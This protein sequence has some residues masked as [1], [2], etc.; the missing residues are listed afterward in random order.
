MIREWHNS[1]ALLAL[2]LEAASGG[3]LNDAGD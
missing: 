2:R 1:V 3:R